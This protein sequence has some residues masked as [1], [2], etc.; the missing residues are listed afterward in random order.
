MASSL[1]TFDTAQ[2]EKHEISSFIYEPVWHEDGSLRDF[3][4]VY[5][6]DIFAR[7]WLAIYH[8]ED[9][10]GALL[11]E[12]TLMD[13]YSLNMMER[14]LTEK[15]YSFVTYMPMVN[16]HLYF[17][18]IT[19]LPAPYA[20][21][22]MTNITGYA[23]QDTKL[24]FLSNIQQMKN[25]AVLL[26]KYD[27]GQMEPVFVSKDF[28]AM[29]ECSVSEAKTLMKGLNFYKTTHPE[30]RPLV[31]SMLKH[32]IAYDG[33][34]YLTL[35]KI[36]AKGNYIW[37]NVH[38]AFI[39]DFNEHYIYCTYTDV[40]ALK[41]YENRLRSVYSSMGNSFYQDNDK[42]LALFRVNLS[43]DNIEEIKGKD[44]F[45]TD[46][47]TYS[48]TET[49]M[50]RAAHFP[51]SSER[52]QFLK[53]FHKDALISGYTSGNVSVSQILYSIRK[54]G[55]SCFVNI[56]AAI[57]R[58][59]L[60]GDV[61]AFITEQECNS[62]KVQQTLE[63]KI[64]AQQFDMVAYLT[65]GHYG[66]T[67]GDESNIKYGSIFPTSRSGDYGQYL[68]NQV[69]PVLTGTEDQKQEAI[70]ALSLDTLEKELAI[71]EPYV[72]NI[73]IEMD[74]E[75]Y[76][77]RFDFYRIDPEA[78]FYIL[79]KSDTTEIQ[80]EQ[81][82]Y[83]ERLSVALEAANQANVAKTAFLSSMSHE[84]RT[85]MNAIIGLDNIALSDPDLS[86]RTREHLEKIG[87]S[88]RHLLGLIN[89]ILDMSRIESGRM[90]LKNEEFSFNTM[91]EQINTMIH[92]Q[93][94]DRGL[95]Y[96]CSLIGHVD[97]Y[98]IGDD[99][100]LKQVLINI[101]GNA[102]KFTPAPG[103]VSFLVERISE[104]DGQ[105]ALRF[106]I[107]D[108][109]IGMEQ[110]YLPKI[111]EAFSQENSSST[112]K[113]GSTGL[114]M[115]I[116]K[117]IV[118]MMN[119]NIS[120]ESEKGVGTTF[121]V[122]VTLRNSEREHGQLENV[123]P[124]TLNVLVIDDEPV[125]CEHAK[126]VLEEIGIVADTC[127]S[128]GEALEMIRLKSARRE[129]YNLIFV[130]W[131][132]PD[133]DGI[134][135]TREIRKIIG[136]DSAVIVLTAYNWDEIEED[137][138]QAGVDSFMAKPLFASNVVSAFQQAMANKEASQEQK[139]KVDLTG[140]RILLA[141]DNEI[142]AEI[143]MEICKMRD[144]EVD[145]AENGQIAVDLFTGH[146]AGY[147]DAVLMDMRMPV[148]DGL[149]ATQTIRASGHPDSKTIL[150]IAL[151]AN[152]FDEDVQRSLQAGMNAHLTK[153][154]DPEFLFQTLESLIRE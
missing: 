66:V 89:D 145:H 40:T 58:Q 148:M 2:Y 103:T 87:G 136:S 30:D 17:E 122:N 94:Q 65:D 70:K 75:T 8:N 139:A 105:S 63:S 45:A 129:A 150:I 78:R 99:M 121:T 31:R 56:S 62:E 140:R 23:A 61:I 5:A 143:M 54:D 118:E 16:L 144:L 21:F 142:N 80:R 96:E 19:G 90:N 28:A 71:S 93:C 7:D 153:P 38:Y 107:K 60:T 12:S 47:M 125:A 32:R 73:G 137:A 77:K 91:L 152:A 22:Y 82:A 41:Q 53:S 44:L 131:K 151:T 13:E 46:S 84:I 67:I 3:R 130:D 120:V 146:P 100:K 97:D 27:D 138:T 10:L 74:G 79:L 59:P 68:S 124:R 29:M 49:M 111:F 18:P 147:Y 9:Y 1:L 141:E 92:S 126:L 55:H 14:F 76:Y 116:T 35:Q 108:T 25:N 51:I 115:A 134:E 72:V 88:A 95:T 85:P 154:V 11:K 48:F 50:Q 149:T 57:T 114:G 133:Q 52:A 109:G 39:D 123:D 128:G 20:G 104:F 132:M 135:V 6:S 110:S 81:I 26:Q 36:T 69:Y 37:C 64:L 119:G 117:N 34:T 83:N 24:H 42:T 86:D 101:L 15:P 43:R 102:V 127:L 33:G 106:I 112:N 4:V 113:Y 98:Y